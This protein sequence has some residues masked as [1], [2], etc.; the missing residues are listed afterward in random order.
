M[1]GFF[2]SLAPQPQPSLHFTSKLLRQRTFRHSH[3]AQPS[4]IVAC[5]GRW[6]Q[7]Q[8]RDKLSSFLAWSTLLAMMTL[9]A[10]VVNIGKG[11]GGGQ[12]DGERTDAELDQI[13][14]DYLTKLADA[15]RTTRGTAYARFS[16]RFQESIADQIR[17]ILE[18]A[19]A[20]G[21]Y[22]AREHIFFD[23]AVTG[24]KRRRTGIQ[25]C[26]VVLERRQVEC[27]LFFSTSRLFRNRVALPEL[28]EEITQKWKRR[29]VFAAQN[30]DS[31][32]SKTEMMLPLFGWMDEY[33]TKASVAHIQ[34]AHVGLLEGGFV[35]GTETYGYTGTP[36]EGLTT[37]LGRPKRKLAIDERTS[38]VVQLIFHWF[39]A[40]GVTIEE[41]ARRLHQSSHPVPAKASAGWTT[42]VV[43]KMLRNERYRGNWA[44]GKMKARFLRKEDY[45]RQEPREK[46][47]AQAS[48]EHLRI[49]SDELW[50]AVQQ[51][52][53]KYV[54]PSGRPPT[55]PSEKRPRLIEGLVFCPTHDRPLVVC[56]AHGKFLRCP[57]CRRL[58]SAE[59]PLFTHLRR[60]HAERQLLR[61]LAET[62]VRDD[63]A[64]FDLVE[65]CRVAAEAAVLPDPDCMADLE[66]RLKSLT[67][68]ID[69]NRR[70]VGDGVD[71]QAE[72][73]R[74]LRDLTSQRRSAQA[75][76]DRLQCSASQ[77][78]RI[79]TR[80][81]ILGRLV[82]LD[83]ILTGELGKDPDVIIKLRRVLEL[84]TGGRID[85]EQR[86]ER[87][88]KKG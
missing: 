26:K 64:V 2:Y 13:H 51:R 20:H 85:L 1:P 49:I 46:P 25:N 45:T 24:K 68:K 31:A 28:F 33:F 43:G 34:S 58:P 36:V 22:V 18:W 39:G 50:F 55:T 19:R 66:R 87:T 40:D 63:A 82:E 71:E 77:Q 9:L 42:K 12:D 38:K 5:C 11:E 29:C 53:V 17:S 86:G 83:Q 56:G 10:T 69:F 4:P 65:Q 7:G 72:T 88:D 60:E 3:Y 44:Y 61:F 27:A 81:E 8:I 57:L 75:E 47:L 78:P 52:L 14:T 16:T 32:D 59:R 62:I 74:I 76:L 23:T 35:F 80:G 15:P 37:R 79:L 54:R 48:F 67:N 70:T 73:E 41:I 21:I 6:Q 30:L 84:I